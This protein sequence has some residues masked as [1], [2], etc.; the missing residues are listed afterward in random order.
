M[1]T[2]V[3]HAGIVGRPGETSAQHERHHGH[4]ARGACEIVECSVGVGEVAR[5]LP[6]LDAMAAAIEDHDQR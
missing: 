1:T 2:Q 4:P 5:I 6:V 3:G